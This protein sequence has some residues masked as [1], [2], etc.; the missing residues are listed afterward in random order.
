MLFMAVV[1]VRMSWWLVTPLGR[2]E[3]QNSEDELHIHA[4]PPVHRRKCLYFSFPLL[5]PALPD[6]VSKYNSRAL[7][8]GY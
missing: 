2:G 3:P 6:P 1:G 5:S 4:P 8:A 7:L